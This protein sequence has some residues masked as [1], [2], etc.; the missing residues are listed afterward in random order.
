VMN[1]MARNRVNHVKA[2]AKDL[3]PVLVPVSGHLGSLCK[4]QRTTN[5]LTKNGVNHV[6]AQ[7]NDLCFVL[8]PIPSRKSMS[9]TN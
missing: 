5:L 7:V 3:W 2:Q 9:M 4:Y 1:I 8:V 6:K